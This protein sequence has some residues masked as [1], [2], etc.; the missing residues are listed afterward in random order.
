MLWSWSCAALLLMPECARLWWGI[1]SE[2]QVFCTV[3]SLHRS[4]TNIFVTIKR[5]KRICKHSGSAQLLVRLPAFSKRGRGQGSKV[6]WD[7]QGSHTVP[8]RGVL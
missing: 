8:F 4:I 6:E 1:R 2:P 3:Q 7:L 5:I